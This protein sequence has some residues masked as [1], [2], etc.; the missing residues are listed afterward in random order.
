MNEPAKMD[1]LPLSNIRIVNL[2]S[3]NAP[4]CL[5]PVCSCNHTDCDR[6][7]IFFRYK[8]VEERRWK[9]VSKMVEKEYDG[10]RP[11]PTCDPER[12]QIFDSSK[13]PEEL[14]QRL[15]ERS[16]FKVIENYDKADERRTRTL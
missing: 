15:R 6:G 16:D 11:C 7:W 10:T 4:K 13:S 8:V 12:A 1:K 3:G 2:I 5:R 9:G 14:A